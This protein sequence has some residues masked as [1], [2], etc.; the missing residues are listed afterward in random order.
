[1]DQEPSSSKRVRYDDPNYEATLL[2]WFEEVGSD[3]SDIGSEC[4]ENFAIESDHD[5]EYE[6]EGIKYPQI[7]SNFI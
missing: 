6:F 2:K 1:M 4:D 7:L 3:N 5:T